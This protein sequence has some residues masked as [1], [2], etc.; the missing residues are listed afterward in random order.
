MKLHNWDLLQIQSAK[1]REKEK[2]KHKA[3]KELQGL[4]KYLEE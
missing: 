1:K 3:Q 4:K 2:D